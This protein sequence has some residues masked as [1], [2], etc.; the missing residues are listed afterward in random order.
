MIHFVRTLILLAVLACL[1]IAGVWVTESCS[2]KSF[3]CF[4]EHGDKKSA[5]TVISAVLQKVNK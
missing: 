3:S 4:N 5:D 1:G 2:L